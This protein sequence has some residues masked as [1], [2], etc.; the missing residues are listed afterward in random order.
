VLA[1]RAATQTVV[2]VPRPHLSSFI[3]GLALHADGG[4][5]A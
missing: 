3:T 1:A 4:A 2:R 5:A